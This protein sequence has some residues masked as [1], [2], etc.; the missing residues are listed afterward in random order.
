[1]DEANL[2]FQL[3]D[4]EIIESL[5]ECDENETDSDEDGENATNTK[6]L[7]ALKAFDALKTV[8]KWAATEDKINCIQPVSYTHLDVYKRQYLSYMKNVIP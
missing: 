3:T 2:G 8:L 4:E 6:P 7:M 5:H 1:M